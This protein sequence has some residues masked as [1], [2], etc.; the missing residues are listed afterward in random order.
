MWWVIWNVATCAWYEGNHILIALRATSAV[1]FPCH[2]RNLKGRTRNCRRRCRYAHSS[3]LARLPPGGD[4]A[5]RNLARFLVKFLAPWAACSRRGRGGGFWKWPSAPPPTNLV[6]TFHGQAIV[7][8][9]K[10]KVSVVQLFTIIIL[11]QLLR[12][13]PFALGDRRG[14]WMCPCFGPALGGPPPRGITSP[15]GNRQL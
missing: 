8:Y 10:R 2:H 14:I 6:G 12:V 3:H 13:S 5:P 1:P 4:C 15:P 7:H 9:E 11:A